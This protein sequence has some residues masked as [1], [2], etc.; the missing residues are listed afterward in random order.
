[1]YVTILE[2]V[3]MLIICQVADSNSQAQ[4]LVQ[5]LSDLDR[6]IDACEHPNLDKETVT[7]TELND[8]LQVYALHQW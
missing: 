8:S 6:R 4:R 3:Q 7:P 1:M 2:A 5:F